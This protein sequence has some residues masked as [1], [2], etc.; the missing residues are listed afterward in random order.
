MRKRIEIPTP[1]S[2]K[3][4]AMKTVDAHQRHCDVC[5]L[6]VHDICHY[7]DTILKPN[8]LQEINF[9]NY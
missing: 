3:W 6:N 1:C 5:K 8:R 9:E 2:E 7:W 4:S